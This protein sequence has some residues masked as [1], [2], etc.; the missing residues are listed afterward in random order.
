VADHLLEHR[1]DVRR[2]DEDRVGVCERLSAPAR[3]LRP[4]AHRVLQLGSVRLDREARAGR[5]GDRT[6]EQN[7]VR[8]DEVGRQERAER[9]CVRVDVAIALGRREVLEKPRLQTLVAVEHEDGQEPVGQLRTTIALS[10]GRGAPGV[11][12]GRRS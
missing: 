12:P 5:C 6:A 8:E 10:R 3:E 7:V 9:R 2:P 11:A 4:A 1:A